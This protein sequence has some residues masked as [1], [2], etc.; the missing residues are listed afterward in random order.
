MLKEKRWHSMAGRGGKIF[1]LY[2]LGESECLREKFVYSENFTVYLTR[3]YDTFESY[4]PS[5]R[6]LNFVCDCPL[7]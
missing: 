2:F 6:D 7:R 1:V 4:G 5:S 3:I